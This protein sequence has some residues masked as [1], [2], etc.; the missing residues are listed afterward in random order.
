MKLYKDNVTKY[1]SKG[2]YYGDLLDVAIF[3]RDK[4]MLRIGKEGLD[5]NE[6]IGCYICHVK[7]GFCKINIIFSMIRPISTKYTK[8]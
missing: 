2:N 8:K 3:N 5:H 1:G 4:E 6:F 7:P